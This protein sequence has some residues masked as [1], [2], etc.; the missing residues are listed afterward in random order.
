MFDRSS[1]TI[2]VVM[3]L[4]AGCSEPAKSTREG[5]G[6]GGSS[7]VGNPVLATLG[8]SGGPSDGDEVRKAD[9]SILFVGNSHTQMHDLPGLAGGMIQFQRPGKTVYTHYMPVAFLED[10]AR[11][12]DC[13]EEI[14]ARPWKFVVLQSQKISASGHFDFSRKEGIDFARL[15]KSRG[16]KVVFYPEWGLKG[17]AGDGVRQEKV[18]REMAQAAG[19]EMAPVARA[20]DLALAER[21]DLLL[22]G[23]DGNHQSALGAFLT[24][25][26]LVGQITGESPAGLAAY[27][28]DAAAEEDRKFLATMAAKAI[29]EQTSDSKRP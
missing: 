16:A 22:H 24:G 1:L 21:P 29:S 23:I 3:G 15:A 11:N 25:C 20:W 5:A 4:M 12:P 18:Y 10:V 27:S 9:F 13:R 7:G 6:G 26:V 8:P 17:V 28:Y 2:L 14:E 19:V